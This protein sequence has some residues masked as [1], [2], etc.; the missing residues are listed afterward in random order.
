MPLPYPAFNSFSS[1]QSTLWIIRRNKSC[2]GDINHSFLLRSI[3]S[4]WDFSQRTWIYR[5]QASP[6]L[7][8]FLSVVIIWAA[9]RERVPNIPTFP[10]YKKNLKSR[11]HTKRRMGVAIRAHHS[12]GMAT[13]QAITL[14]TFLH[15]TAHFSPYLEFNI[16]LFL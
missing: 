16:E 5:K 12:F 9:I 7:L 11:R 4:H 8:Q 1:R 15:D 14:G 2:L 6:I 13:T 10:H 3:T